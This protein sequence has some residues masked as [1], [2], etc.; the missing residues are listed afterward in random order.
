MR[1]RDPRHVTCVFAIAC[2][3]ASGCGAIA[4]MSK[5]DYTTQA[6]TACERASDSYLKLPMLARDR[7]LN[8]VQAFR[9]TEQVGKRYDKALKGLEPPED[10][11][12]AHE[13]LLD[14]LASPST[15][16]VGRPNRARLR[17][18]EKAYEDVGMERC[19]GRVRD[20]LRNAPAP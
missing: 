17:K 2:L 13:N 14:V 8:R 7:H 9:A 16:K 20:D 4:P 10:L 6:E 3:L 12:D 1:R 15:D 18:L 5:G 11:Q 19:A